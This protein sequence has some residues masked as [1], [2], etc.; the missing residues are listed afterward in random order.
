[1]HQ[2]AS[3]KVAVG[4]QVSYRVITE[5]PEGNGLA[6][7]IAASIRALSLAS[8][9]DGMQIPRHGWG[10]W[11][12]SAKQPEPFRPEEAKVFLDVECLVD[13]HSWVDGFVEALSASMV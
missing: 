4:V 1:M 9:E 3:E 2:L 11:L 8:S 6:G 12:Q 7:R 10:T 13:G 5:G